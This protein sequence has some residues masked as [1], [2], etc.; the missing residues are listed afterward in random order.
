[1][2][3]VYPM[4]FHFHQSFTRSGFPAIAIAGYSMIGNLQIVGQSPGIGE[5]VPGMDQVVHLVFDQGFSDALNPAVGITS[6]SN[7]YPEHLPLNRLES[8]RQLEPERIPA[9]EPDD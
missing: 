8:M 9:P 6:D 3:D 5:E 4:L 2:A 1:M 7:P